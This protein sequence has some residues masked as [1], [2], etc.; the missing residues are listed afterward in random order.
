METSM[1]LIYRNY[2]FLLRLKANLSFCFFILFV[3]VNVYAQAPDCSTITY[4]T[5]VQSRLEIDN[6]DRL[7]CISEDLTADYI[8]INDIDAAPTLTWNGGSGFEPIGSFEN[9]FTGTLDGGGFSITDLFINSPN[10]NFIG[11]FGF[12]GTGSEVTNLGLENVDITGGSGVGGLAGALMDGQVSECFITGSITGEVTGNSSLAI[13]G[14]IGLYGGTGTVLNSFNSASVKGDANV[15]GIVGFSDETSNF[16]FSI[17]NSYT[18]GRIMFSGDDLAGAIDG[19]FVANKFDSYYNIESSDIGVGTGGGFARTTLEMKTQS[20]F[21]SWDFSNIWAIDEGNSYP[22]LQ[23]NPPTILPGIND[24]S[25]VNPFSGGIGSENDPFLI[26]NVIQLQAMDDF[27]NYTFELVND[28]DASSTAGWNNGRGFDPIG[29]STT[30]FFG[31][32]RGN[33]YKIIGLT[34]NRPDSN[35]VG[36][37]AKKSVYTISNFALEDVNIT[38]NNYVGAITGRSSAGLNSIY[39]TGSV[40]GD[41]IVGGL[42]GYNSSGSYFISSIGFS[43]STASVSADSIAGG[44]VG[45][46]DNRIRDS[47]STGK[48]FSTTQAGGLVGHNIGDITDSYWN[49]ETSGLSTSDGGK[50]LSTSEMKL[51]SSFIDW[52]F[53][54]AWGINERESFPYLQSIVQSPLPGSNVGSV[55]AGGLGTI[56]NP[57]QIQNVN[58]FQNITN[59]LSSYF[60]LNSDINAAGTALWN[61]GQGFTPIGNTEFPFKGMIN[62]NG[63]AVNRITINRALQDTIGVFSVLGSG[64]QVKDLGLEGVNIEGQNTVGALA[65]IATDSSSIENTYITGRVT[66]INNVGGLLGSSNGKIDYAYTANTVSGNENVGGIAGSATSESNLSNIYASGNVSGS[67]NTGGILGSNTDATILDSYWNTETGGVS[68]GVGVGAAGETTGLTTAEM[69]QPGSFT[70][71]DFDFE[72]NWFIV[73]NQSYPWLQN[74]EQDPAPEPVTLISPGDGGDVAIPTMLEWKAFP[75]ANSYEIQIGTDAEMESVIFDTTNIQS[76]TLNL[77]SATLFEENQTYYWKVRPDNAN[78]SAV[79]A[80]TVLIVT[81]TEPGTDIP[82]SYALS[83]NYPNPFNPNTSIRFS[84]PENSHVNLEVFDLLG[85]RISKLVDEDL[86]PGNYSVKFEASNFSSG[87]YIYRIK[88]GD[89]VSTKKMLLLK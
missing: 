79:N 87:V 46:N 63:Y 8:L 81:S 76:P 86:A 5:D 82:D 73:V 21:V 33:G 1:Y 44:L 71:W 34:I 72:G 14:I 54:I 28:I 50:P 52:N 78:W 65:G 9:N 35:Y 16:S 32:F 62:G 83:Q 41:S 84:V 59:H 58:Q 68:A 18:S 48:V 23:S 49:T 51:Q 77:V 12:L 15:G 45:F 27:E 53:S 70:N 74:N 56:G 66:G 47:Y 40:Q 80:F 24:T 57:Y 64:A 19:S 60:L 29:S 25:V 31:P 88:S 22:Y 85:R 69:M 55:Y 10:S 2:N 30:S 20:T 42:T 67:I 7:Q 89:F 3:S 39:V 61:N 37:F 75:E 36:L 13:G 17:T 26:E 11:F 4:N 43:Y 6:L 38:G